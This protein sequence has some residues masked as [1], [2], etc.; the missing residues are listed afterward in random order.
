MHSL[1]RQGTKFLPATEKSS[2]DERFFD[3]IAMKKRFL[4]PDPRSKTYD[5]KC[6]VDELERIGQ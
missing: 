5:F 2:Q 6:I 3:S 4:H 1:L